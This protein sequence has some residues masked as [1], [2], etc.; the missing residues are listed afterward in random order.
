MSLLNELSEEAKSKSA[1]S[2]TEATETTD[3]TLKTE[4]VVT[5]N[6]KTVES[7][8]TEILTEKQENVK[9]DQ[10]ILQ[11]N[12]EQELNVEKKQKN[13][14]ANEELAEAN[15]F[16]LKNPTKTLEDYKALKIP[17]GDISEEDLMKQ[18]LSVKEGKTESEIAY[19]LKRLEKKNP[20]PDF[21][22][23]FENDESLDD[24]KLKGDR[25]RLIQNAREWRDGFVKEQLKFD[26]ENQE[27]QTITNDNPSIEQFI[28]DAQKAHEEYT[29]NFRTEIYK[30]L[31][32][33]NQIDL[34]V[35]GSTVGFVPS[36][37]FKT[38]MRLSA[39]NIGGI[40]KE[41]FDENGNITNAKSFITEN[42]LWAN[43]KTRQPL[44]DFMMEQAVLK[45][46]AVRDKE[47]RNITLDNAN[48]VHVAESSDKGEIV[49]KRLNET[50]SGTF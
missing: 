45:D 13:V 38:E 37:E 25:E 22:D 20:D 17:S 11:N 27:S 23:E 39:E 40:G 30:A 26:D 35:Q 15:A 6:T 49:D 4:E 48:A 46:R 34:D 28:N 47:R 14:F 1:S 9:V 21:D 29:Q 36:E 3:Q 50:K 19:E 16:L 8:K 18:F 24:L 42:T 5:E 2:G 43:P 33:I 10:P 41:F 32:L 44:L 7:E 12:Q 31:P